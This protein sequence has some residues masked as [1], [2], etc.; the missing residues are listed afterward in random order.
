[1]MFQSKLLITILFIFLS[2]LFGSVVLAAGPVDLS[3]AGITN[4]HVKTYHVNSWFWPM[5]K[6]IDYFLSEG[7][8]PDIIY[9]ILAVP[10]IT[11]VIAFFRQIIGI[12]T[13][14][15]YMP[16]LIALSFM[17]LGVLFGMAVLLLVILVSYV[18]REIVGKLNLLYIPRVSFLFSV[19]SL[20]FFIIIWFSLNF[21]S[22]VTIGAAIFP[23][24]MISTISERISSTQS[25]EGVSGAL[26]GTIQTIL[27]ALVA[28]YFVSWPWLAVRIIALPEIV[29]LPLIGNLIT[30]KFT[31]LRLIEYFRFRTLF[32][33]N[34]EE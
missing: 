6:M 15:L 34:I 13:F 1:M 33:D 30:G 24:L 4:Y 22:P 11:F 2:F 12:S 5:S 17:L 16:L 29:L 25:E 10:F 19:L 9:M 31:G 32:K 21:G 27:V 3:F 20:S 23:M 28:Y 14:G 8:R 26:R 7:V 18:L